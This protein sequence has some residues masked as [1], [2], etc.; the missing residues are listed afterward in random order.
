[1]CKHKEYDNFNQSWMKIN[2]LAL[3]LFINNNFELIIQIDEIIIFLEEIGIDSDKL[4]LICT[5]GSSK[6]CAKNCSKIRMQH[7][8]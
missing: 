2:V 1:M 5:S 4:K 6:N 8:K 3:L 7:I